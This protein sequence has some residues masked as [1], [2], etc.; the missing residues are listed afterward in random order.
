MKEE[1]GRGRGN[2]V[3]LGEK[4]TILF[5]KLHPEMKTL[6]PY[7]KGKPGTVARNS[8]DPSL[9]KTPGGT[10][11]KNKDPEGGRKGHLIAEGRLLF[12]KEDITG[13]GKH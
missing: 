12:K 13:G 1:G 8:E 9:K 2:P 5:Q 7:K 11:K 4:E 10:Q 3:S 6:I